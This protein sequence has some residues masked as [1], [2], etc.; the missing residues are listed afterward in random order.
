MPRGLPVR[1]GHMVDNSL[2]S[3]P[4]QANTADEATVEVSDAALLALGP[5][6]PEQCREVNNE[7]GQLSCRNHGK[8]S[9][10]AAWWEYKSKADSEGMSSEAV[11]DDECV[12]SSTNRYKP[13][14]AGDTFMRWSGYSRAERQNLP[15]FLQWL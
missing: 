15:L 1:L 8:D 13:P 2:D 10:D 3:V 4:G 11:T 6:Y 5:G 9:D 12:G 7:L 14:C